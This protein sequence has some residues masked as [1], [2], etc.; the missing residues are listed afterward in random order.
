MFL[1]KPFHIVGLFLLL[2]AAL[3]HPISGASAGSDNKKVL[4]LVDDHATTKT[5]STFLDTIKR[6][7]Y[8]VTVSL[9]TSDEVQLQDVETW[10]F[11]KLVVLGGQSSTCLDRFFIRCL[12]E[13]YYIVHFHIMCRIWSW[14]YSEEAVGVL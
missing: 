7:G 3:I 14:Y 9:A 1:D 10:L 2:V 5:H 12:Q 8:D 13:S 6:K 11:D 4:V